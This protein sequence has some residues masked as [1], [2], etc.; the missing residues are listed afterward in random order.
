[1]FQDPKVREAL[2]YAFD[3][4][5]STR[6][7]LT[8]NI[9]A[10]DP[11]SRTPRWRRRALPSPEEL[12]ILNPL[13]GPDPAGGFHHRIQPAGDR[14]LRQRA[15]QSRQ[16]GGACWTKP[17]GRSRTASGSR[18][19]SRSSSRFIDDDPATSARSCRSSRTWRSMGITATVRV[20]DSAQYQS[21]MREFR[22]RHDQQDLGRV[23]LA[24][25][26]AAGILGLARPPTR[27]GSDNLDR[28]QESGGRQA[29]RADRHRADARGPDHP[30]H[31][32]GPCA[33]MELLLGAELH[34]WRPSASPTG[35]S[36][37]C[38]T[39]GRIRSTAMA[40]APGGSIRRRKRRSPARR[41]PSNRRHRLPRYRRRPRRQ[42][43]PSGN[44][45]A[46]PCR[47]ATPAA[48]ADRGQSPLIYAGGGDCRG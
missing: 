24:W 46:A 26:R 4:E 39:S 34:I 11:I 28:H 5:W 22:L 48:P 40:A 43:H 37:A 2:I 3:F 8:A 27:T 29:D 36:S 20:V 10:R 19:A 15:R 38:R 32:A 9:R 13:E 25:Q 1:M 16:G 14:R 41:M 6:R 33:A 7:W 17:A 21:R 35:T 23:D 30:L 45:A 47:A 42:P 18:T 12:E 31:G 44:H